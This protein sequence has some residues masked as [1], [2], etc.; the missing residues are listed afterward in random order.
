MSNFN[1]IAMQPM[2][3]TAGMA[4]SF[5]GGYSTAAGALFGTMIAARFDGTIVPLY[6]GFAVLGFCALLAVF[7]VE[8][9]SGL[10]RGE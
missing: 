6:T 7:A 10:F 1:A 4:A 3:Q 2:G 8:G 5:T 9:R